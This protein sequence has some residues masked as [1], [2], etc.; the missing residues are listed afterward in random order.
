MSAKR[1]ERLSGMVPVCM[2][3]LRRWRLYWRETFVA[4]RTWQAARGRFAIPL[5]AERLPGA[6][7]E[8]FS[9][10]GDLQQ[11]IVAVLRLVVA[12]PEPGF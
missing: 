12:A 8:A 4:S 6:L 11:R 3:T 7:L 5:G 9:G 10:I 1:L 2:R